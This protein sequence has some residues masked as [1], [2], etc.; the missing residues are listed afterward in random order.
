[1]I[2]VVNGYEEIELLSL[3]REENLG[4]TE[5]FSVY[6]CVEEDSFREKVRE[7]LQCR[8]RDKESAL[9]E[10][11]AEASACA[12]ALAETR[13]VPLFNSTDFEIEGG[14]YRENGEPVYY[15]EINLN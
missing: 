3:V 2:D 8:R 10:A 4:D 6:N 15:P 12:E 11:I 13:N 9:E 5:R 7:E 14:D 1:M